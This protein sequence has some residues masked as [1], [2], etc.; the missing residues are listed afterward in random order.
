[1]RKDP[2]AE[3][4]FLLQDCPLRLLDSDLPPRGGGAPDFAVTLEGFH[5][6]CD[7]RREGQW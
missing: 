2:C 3:T 4:P 1:M 6:A 7:G 5:F